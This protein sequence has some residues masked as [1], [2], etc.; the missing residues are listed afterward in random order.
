MKRI[1]AMYGVVSAIFVLG[2]SATFYLGRDLFVSVP[3]AHAAAAAAP[4]VWSALL[5]NFHDPLSRLLV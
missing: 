3:A 5:Q 1:L 2:I 4:S